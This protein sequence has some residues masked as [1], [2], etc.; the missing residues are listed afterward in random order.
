MGSTPFDKRLWAASVFAALSV[1]VSDVIAQILPLNPS[2]YR[3]IP[4]P[5]FSTGLLSTDRG[6]GPSGF[7]WVDNERLLFVVNDRQLS[8][9]EHRDIRTVVFKGVPTIHLWDFRAGT[10]KRYRDEP[11]ADY[12]CVIDGRVYYGL[13]RN[14]KKVTFEGV[15]GQESQQAQPAPRIADNGQPLPRGFDR[16]GCKEYWY[17]DVPRPHGGSAT[18][19]RPEHGILERTGSGP[20]GKSANPKSKP[21]KWWNHLGDKSVEIPFPQEWVSGPT[22]YSNLVP[23]YLFWR[24]VNR[25]ERGVINRFYLWV[26][27]SNTV[28]MFDVVG[29]E[30]W[31]ALY[32]PRVTKAGLVA[33]SNAIKKNRRGDYDLG[34]Q[35]VYVFSGAPVEEF[36]SGAAVDASHSTANRPLS[37]QQLVSGLI[38]EVSQVSPDGCRIVVV[39][40]PWDKED[41]HLRFEAMDFCQKGS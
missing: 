6:G 21:F 20:E 29:S 4:A 36:I 16:L 17:A 19:L 18:P 22:V 5:E 23:G 31:T 30:N 38:H 40:D 28:R 34:P 10:I 15:F 2:H 1:L 9:K 7:Q 8:K 25:L 11:L 35:G 39:V 13:K 12:L 14:G 26:P 3:I 24:Q 41:R 27:R 33:M 32:L 37:V